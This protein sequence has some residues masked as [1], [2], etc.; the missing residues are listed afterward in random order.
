MKVLGTVVAHSP[1]L[2]AL[3][4]QD[5]S[6]EGF[7]ARSPFPLVIGAHCGFTLTRADGVTARVDMCVAHCE[8]A[9]AGGPASGFVMGFSCVTDADRQK[10]SGL[11]ASLALEVPA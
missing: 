8:R 9:D 6:E 4:V 1:A 5:I 10:L 11:M 7:A 2:G 3:P